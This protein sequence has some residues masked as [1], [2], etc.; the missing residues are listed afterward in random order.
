MIRIAAS[1]ASVVLLAV[2]VGA[3]SPDAAEADPIRTAWLIAQA[4]GE[5]EAADA[6]LAD[7]ESRMRDATDE[8]RRGQA[9]VLTGT[10]RPTGALDAAAAGFESAATP[11]AEARA[12]LERL[13]WTLRA[14]GSGAAPPELRMEPSD[15]TDIGAQWRAAAPPC[16]ILFD[17]RLDA[18]TTLE[19]L[20]DG[21]AALDADDPAAALAAIEMAAAT[22]DQMRQFTDSL[23]TLGFWVDIVDALIAAARDIA[24]AAQAG[25]LAA[26]AEAQAAYDAAA[27]DAGR[28]DRALAIALGEAAAQATGPAATSSADALRAVIAARDQV[29]GLSILR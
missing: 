6:A 2:L 21:L 3:R 18:E 25:D 9:A 8:A 12:S 16:E 28:A 4:K 10:D 7:A 11:L 5:A 17:L 13:G 15:A 14:L 29:A 26:L 24:L 20:D 19:A 1:L 23:A 27:A 22:V